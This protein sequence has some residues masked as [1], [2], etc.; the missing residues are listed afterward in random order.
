MKNA[1]QN[2]LIGR[3]KSK[4]IF[5]IIASV[6]I[7]SILP[8][9]HTNAL[10]IT[11]PFTQQY[12]QDSSLELGEKQTRQPGNNGKGLEKKSVIEPAFSYLLGM[13]MSYKSSDLPTETTLQPTN[14]IIANGTK[15]YQYM[16]CSNGS[17]RYYSNDQFKDPNTGFTHKSSDACSESSNGHMTAL[18]DSA[19]QQTTQQSTRTYTPTYSPTH[20][21]TQYNTYGGYLNPTASTTCY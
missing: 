19:P 10:P 18:S 20:C 6:L 3:V 7:A 1:R 9:P 8:I 15:K 11:L 2:H 17:Y 14:E 4:R 21:Y 16:L 5:V 12:I 13:K